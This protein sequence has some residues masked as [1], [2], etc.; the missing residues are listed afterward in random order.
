MLKLVNVAHKHLLV[1]NVGHFTV[2][3]TCKV[4]AVVYFIDV[5][6]VVVITDAVQPCIVHLSEV[7]SEDSL[8]QRNGFQ[9]LL[10]IAVATKCNDSRCLI[11]W[12]DVNG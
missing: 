8:R 5:E 9:I 12:V 11:R 10:L 2:V 6:V 4:G 3:I 7:G 1:W